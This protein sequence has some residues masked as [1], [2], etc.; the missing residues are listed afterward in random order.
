MDPS[1][2]TSEELRRIATPQDDETLYIYLYGKLYIYIHIHTYIHIC[3]Y[4]R[5]TVSKPLNL[6][7]LNTI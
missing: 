4:I 1:L 3:I 7:C 5:E 6:K 2:Y